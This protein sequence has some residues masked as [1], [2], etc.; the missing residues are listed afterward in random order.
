MKQAERDLWT[1]YADSIGGLRN[2]PVIAKQPEYAA[3]LD[4]PKPSKYGN[5]KVQVDGITFDSKREAARFQELKFMQQAK[6]IDELEMQP[7]FPLHVMELYRSQAPIVIRTVATYIADFRYCDL[8]TGEIVV[9]DV[10][11]PATREKETYRL[12]RKIAEAVHGI[13]IREV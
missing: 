8:Q 2:D 10:K 4:A 7:A 13:F 5:V 1:K 6:Q 12:K 3:M 11:S 9:E